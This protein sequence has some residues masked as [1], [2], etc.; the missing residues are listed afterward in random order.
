MT[1]FFLLIF[2]FLTLWRPQ[3]WLFPSL[4]GWPILD[5]VTVFAVLSFV[6]ERDDGRLRFPKH[7]MHIYLLVGLWIASMMSH[8]AHTYFA[9]F[10]ATF[11]TVLKPVVFSILLIATFTHPR[12]LR[13]MAWLFVL[14]A[15]IMTWHCLLQKKTGYGFA[16]LPPLWIRDAPGVLRSR[17]YFFGIFGDPNDTAQ[18]LGTAIP[19]AFCLFPKRRWYSFVAGGL[20]SWFLV[21]GVL[22]TGSRGG[23][24][25]MMATFVCLM[26]ALLPPRLYP[27]MIACL[28]G[29]FLLLCPAMSGKLDQ[30]AADRVAIWGDANYAFKHAPVFGV[31]LGMIEE[32]IEQSRA[33]HNAYIMCYSETGLFGYWFWFGLVVLGFSGSLRVVRLLQLSRNDVERS[34]SWFASMAIAAMASYMVSSYF[35]GRAYVFPT[36]MLFS[37]MAGIPYVLQQLRPDEDMD[38]FLTQKKFMVMN[39]IIS[40]SSVLYIYVSILILNVR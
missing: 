32:Y 3:E 14:L 28:L 31:G 26:F 9:G 33:P 13:A 4:F 35:I 38:L 29:G 23:L 21:E 8:I 25:G 15:C 2:A 6:V 12:R 18:F 19:F 10:V 30:S 22:S 39:T 27:V 40:I 5:V 16:D 7:L 36:Y 20:V 1:F 34:L 11:T 37:V 24:L 17:S